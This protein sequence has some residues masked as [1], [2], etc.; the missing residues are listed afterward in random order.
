MGLGRAWAVVRAAF[1]LTASFA[2]EHLKESTSTSL[3]IAPLFVALFPKSVNPRPLE[4]ISN[5]TG[6]R[7]KKYK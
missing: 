1:C 4:I 3:K 5:Q 7:Q 2:P 6:L